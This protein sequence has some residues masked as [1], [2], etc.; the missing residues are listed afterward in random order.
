MVPEPTGENNPHPTARW[1]T[2]GILLFAFLAA[3]RE[4]PFTRVLNHLAALCLL[5]I[6]LLNYRGGRWAH[7]TLSDY[8]VRSLKLFLD[9]F[10]LPVQLLTAPLIVIRGDRPGTKI[11]LLSENFSSP[12]SGDCY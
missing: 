2:A 6:L 11:T 9:V 4:E 7:F 3:F 1:L 5:G 10:I 12:S 8:V